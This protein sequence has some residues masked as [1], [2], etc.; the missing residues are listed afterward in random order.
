MG[1][2]DKMRKKM[3]IIEDVNNKPGK[4]LIKNRYWQSKGIEV[5]R[6]GLPCADYILVDDKVQD[7][8]NR[9]AERGIPPKKM[10][11]LGTYKVA[12]DSK[13]S[14][15]ELVSDICGKQHQRFKDELILAQNNGIKLYIV[16]EN[17]YEDI[18]KKSD[19]YNKPIHD[20]KDLHTWKNPRLFKFRNGKQLY[21]SATKGITLQKACTTMELKYGCK[22]IFCTP[23]ESG[24]V[25]IDLLQGGNDELF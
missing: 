14:I 10:D 3:K 16:V 2:D 11:F 4:H 6:I 7:L 17:D 9:K 13:N 22:F 20:L 1:M 21:P 19:I 15:Q 25:I 5:I 12:V 18:V 8:L 23:M 24:K